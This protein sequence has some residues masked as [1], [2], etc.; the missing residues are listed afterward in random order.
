M[1]NLFEIFGKT[2]YDFKRN[3]ARVIL[4]GI[5]AYFF[6]TTNFY[7]MM[8]IYS[9]I[10]FGN[11]IIMFSF[12]DIT[13]LFGVAFDIFLL[14]F[15]LYGLY[16]YL[17]KISRDEL[18]ASFLIFKRDPNVKTSMKFLLIGGILVGLAWYQSMNLM[19]LLTQMEIN[20]QIALYLLTFWP[21][22]VL[23]MYSVVYY[24]IVDSSSEKII[25]IILGSF[26]LYKFRDIL[27]LISMYILFTI[28]YF[29]V[30]ITRG[31]A[32]VLVIPFT[33]LFMTNFYNELYLRKKS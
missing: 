14:Y 1:I 4:L 8:M 31:T 9:V 7:L 12:I 16:N 26:T 2:I 13:F 17:L 19:K 18:L 33:L 15:G 32:G 3:F 27:T 22:F 21:I 6:F 10:F 23:L 20:S 28:F 24:I 5:I 30:I 11:Y 29:I 25:H